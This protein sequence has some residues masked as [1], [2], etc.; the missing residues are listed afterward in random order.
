MTRTPAPPPP[1]LTR[2][3]TRVLRPQDAATVYTHPRPEFARLTKT[4]A[5][6]RIATGYYAIVPSDR[7]GQHWLP[8]LEAAAAGVAAADEGVDT[9]ALMGLSAARAHGAIPR[10]L[11][12]ATVAAGRHRRPLRLADRDATVLFARRAVPALDVERR[13]GELGP[14]WVTTVEQ[15]VLDLAA[16][17]GFGDLPDEAHAAVRALLPRADREILD[18]LATAQRRRAALD[19]ALGEG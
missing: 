19:R 13:T 5:L 4:G 7:V 16:R 9:V 12:V 2:R 6:H 10:A 14:H 1:E 8:E 18:E 3:L 11:A 15:T 17:P